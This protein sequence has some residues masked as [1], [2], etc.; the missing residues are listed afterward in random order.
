M[1]LLVDR[2]LQGI[3]D[4]APGQPPLPRPPIATPVPSDFG[5]WDSKIQPASLD[6]TIGRILLPPEDP[7]SDKPLIPYWRLVLEEG[8]TAVVET[9]EDLHVP[10]NLAGIGFPP[11][12][13]SLEGL[14]MTNP[15]H[16]D[17]GYRG[18][19]KFTVINMGRQPYALIS[20][21]PICTV[22]FFRVVP[23][24]VPYDRINRTGQTPPRPP[25]NDPDRNL[26][27]TLRQLSP[28]FLGVSKRVKQEVTSRLIWSQITVPVI[29]A[30]V[31]IIVTLVTGYFTNTISSVNDL[32]VKIEGLEKSSDVQQLKSMVDKD[33]QTITTKLN[34]L[35]ARIEKLE[36]QSKAPKQP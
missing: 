24:A 18:K 33:Q 34:A 35:G 31:A 14:L 26:R 25:D 2:D 7:S 13:V 30:I 36:T 27:H 29:T 32:K 4:P 21:E 9:L 16:I 8:K 11:S 15:G 17:P 12:S 6:L 5:R 10:S 19:L 22:L 28:D 3:V 20:G 23:P 1:S